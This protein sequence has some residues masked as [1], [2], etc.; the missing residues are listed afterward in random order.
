MKDHSDCQTFNIKV[1]ERMKKNVICKILFFSFTRLLFST[2]TLSLSLSLS[3][4]HYISLARSL[5]SLILSLSS[6][7]FSLYFLS[8]SH[9][10]VYCCL[11]PFIYYHYCNQQIEFNSN[12]KPLYYIRSRYECTYLLN[13]CL[14]DRFSNRYQQFG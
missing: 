7:L 10:R 13:K 11:L 4:S 1:A 9:T 5:S 3:L 8:R 14:F 2:F 6:A 12:S